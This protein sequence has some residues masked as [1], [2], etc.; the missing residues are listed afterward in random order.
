[1]KLK[2]CG[3]MTLQDV[4]YVNQANTD[5]AGFVFAKSRV[6][7][8]FE[9]AKLL[10]AALNPKIK[11]VGVFVDESYDFIKKC[12]DEKIVDVVQ[13]HG[14][15]EYEMP[16]ETIRAFRMRSAKDIKPTKC[17]FVLFDAFKEGEAGSTGGMF[18]WNIIRE[19]DNKK[20]FFL[21]G[22]INILNIKEAIKQNPYC[23]DIS[24]GAEENGKKSL[25]KIMEITMS[26]NKGG[27]NV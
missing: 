11:A 6:Q 14:D 23:I 1:M 3:L 17:D 16:C 15:F 21:A 20:P 5:Y 10:K 7:I 24:S 26:L 13:F 9:N 18:D 27:K 8:D 22:G 2:I 12:V 19:Y 25:K 4:D